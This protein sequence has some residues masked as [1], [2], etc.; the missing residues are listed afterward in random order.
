MAID[1]PDPLAELVHTRGVDARVS[2]PDGEVDSPVDEGEV[3]AAV[4]ELQAAGVEA[5]TVSLLNSYLNPEQEQR[6]RDIVAAEYPDL[7]VSIS[8]EIVP[9]YGEYERA[10]TTV[11]NDYARPSVI[12]YLDDLDRT[13]GAEG[14]DGRMNIVRSDGGLMSSGAARDRPVE[15]AL[16][17]PSGGVVGAA[18]IASKKGIDDVLT[19]VD[20]TL[21]NSGG[22]NVEE[23]YLYQG[24]ALLASGDTAAATAAYQRAIQLNPNFIPAQ[25]ALDSLPQE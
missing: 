5:L 16:S 17:G 25:E 12:E 13:L 23:T 21:S 1:K 10:L 24:H 3:R 14:F 20:A 9:E 22:R 4:G 18:S 2:S 11:I 6:V 15:M 7:P 19:L 8:S